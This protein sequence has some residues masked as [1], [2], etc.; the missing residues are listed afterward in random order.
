[1]SVKIVAVTG[2]RPP[3]LGLQYGVKAGNPHVYQPMVEA[4]LDESPHLRVLTG[5]ALGVDQI[6]AEACI[7]TLTPFTA[8]IPFVGQESRWPSPSQD[9]Y[10][11]LLDETEKVI[12]VS[13]GGFT[14]EKMQRRN[15]WMVDH[16]DEL[17]AWWDGSSGG[18]AN[19]IAYARKQ[20]VPVIE[21][22]NQ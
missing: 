6:M 9:Y 2:H 3:K 10:Q 16:A 4:L 14:A 13:D 20:G 12:V 15:E 1:M 22:W 19:C 5:M 11:K 8:C 21:R 18:T 7:N 17:W